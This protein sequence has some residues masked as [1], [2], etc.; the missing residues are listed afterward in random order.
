[1]GAGGISVWQL[2]ILLAIVVLV[3][4]TKRLGNLG[5]D[6]GKAIKGFKQGINDKDEENAP[7]LE[8]DPD[9]ADVDV[10]QNARSSSD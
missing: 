4:G 6:L 8:A 5:Q 1:M 10:K 2:L 7:R 9:P 3:F